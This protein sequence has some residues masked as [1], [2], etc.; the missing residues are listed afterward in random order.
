MYCFSKNNYLTLYNYFN[1]VV[2]VVV[3]VYDFLWLSL[4]H[5]VSNF[6]KWVRKLF[7]NDLFVL[8]HFS[9][10]MCVCI[11][12]LF[13]LVVMYINEKLKELREFLM[14]NLILAKNFICIS[15]IYCIHESFCGLTLWCINVIEVGIDKKQPIYLCNFF[16]SGFWKVRKIVIIHLNQAI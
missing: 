4:Y 3:H 10:I 11:Y 9:L 15:F 16:F 5:F 12:S 2:V 6:I 14:G 13:P 7:S 1:F 8:F